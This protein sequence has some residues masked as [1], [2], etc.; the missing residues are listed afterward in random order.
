LY[1]ESFARQS[2][3]ALFGAELMRVAPGEV[4]VALP[5][6]GNLGQQ[7]GLLHAGVVTSIADVACGYSALTLMPAGADVISVEK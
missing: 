4:D 1:R 6:R 5:F 3:M 2:L 7:N